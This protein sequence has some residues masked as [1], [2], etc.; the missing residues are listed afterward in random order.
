MFEISPMQCAAVSA[1]EKQRLAFVD[2]IEKDSIANTH[3][4][5]QI[6]G[7][8]PNDDLA[9]EPGYESVFPQR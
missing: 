3:E 2:R 9:T 7:L 4:W 1:E 5:C 8:D 6:G